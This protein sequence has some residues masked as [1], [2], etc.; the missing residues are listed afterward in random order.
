MIRL[1]DYFSYDRNKETS[2]NKRK[3]FSGRNV[4]QSY[5]LPISIYLNF[6]VIVKLCQSRQ[7]LNTWLTDAFNEDIWEMVS[8]LSYHGAIKN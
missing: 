1:L 6:H 3:S 5:S 8:L 2:N 7:L 4:K